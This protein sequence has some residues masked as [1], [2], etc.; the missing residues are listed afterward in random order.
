MMFHSP[1]FYADLGADREFN[2]CLAQGHSLRFADRKAEAMRE[3]LRARLRTNSPSVPAADNILHL[4][5]TP[6]FRGVPVQHASHR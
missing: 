4:F 6:G 2:R 5:D 3:R 1:D